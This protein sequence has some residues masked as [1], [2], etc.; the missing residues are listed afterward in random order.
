[1]KFIEQLRRRVSLV[2]QMDPP[3]DQ[4]LLP[5]GQ[6]VMTVQ[7]GKFPPVIHGSGYWV[8]YDLPPGPRTL[9]WRAEHY[10]DGQQSVDVATLPPLAP[11]VRLTATAP[12]PVTITL[13]T[14]TLTRGSVG[15]PYRKAVTTSGGKPP[16]TFDAIGLPSGLAIDIQTGV[17]AGTTYVRG[18]FQVQVSVR[19]HNGSRDARTYSFSIVT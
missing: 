2:V 5:R 14:Q 1:M 3:S 17:I 8:F 7:G 4:P 16:L 19:D 18:T 6:V 10:Q 15:N 9:S 13:T 11:V 12:P